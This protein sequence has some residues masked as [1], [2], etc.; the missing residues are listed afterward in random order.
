MEGKRSTRENTSS[1]A[2]FAS[3]E[4]PGCFFSKA[5]VVLPS[6]EIPEAQL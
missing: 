2:V 5:T 6:Q 3:P 4:S 1:K